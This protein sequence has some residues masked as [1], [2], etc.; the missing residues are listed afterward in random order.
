MIHVVAI[1]SAHAGQ[2]PKLLKA[3]ADVIPAVRA[4]QGCVEYVVTTDAQNADPAFGLDTVVV[5]EKWESPAAL[6]AHHASAHM[7]EFATLIADLLANLSVH[8]LQ[9]V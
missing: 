8:V 7:S 2:R 9:P 4:E 5:V 6:K 3:F 1:L